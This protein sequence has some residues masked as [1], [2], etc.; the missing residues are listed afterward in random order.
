MSKTIV[1]EFPHFLLQK[2]SN[3]D[4]IDIDFSI[5]KR[6]LNE[7]RV[8]FDILSYNDLLDKADCHPDYFATSIPVGSI[9]F[10][11][12]FYLLFYGISVINPIEVPK[13]LRKPPFIK[14]FYKICSYEEIESDKVFFIKNASSFKDFCLIGKK[15]QIKKRDRYKNG[16]FAVSEVVKPLAEYRVYVI[17][18]KICNI[19]LYKG[20]PEIFLDLALVKRAIKRISAA[21]KESLPRSYTLD[22]MITQNGCEVL[23]MHNFSAVGLYSQVWDD[24]LIIG[25]IDGNNYIVQNF[26]Q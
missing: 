23:E 20:N 3:I 9:Q 16:L 25:Y 22:F 15:S 11:H 17:R 10:V 26:K 1:N 4:Y 6:T 14:R 18:G 7:N 5:V 8:H 2:E 12:A 19:S 24:K 21:K 13:C